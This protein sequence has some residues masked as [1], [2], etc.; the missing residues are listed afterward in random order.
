M[1][2]QT[3]DESAGPVTSSV[4]SGLTPHAA[5]IEYVA[6]APSMRN[7]PCATFKMRISP[8]CRFSPSATSA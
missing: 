4:R 1:Q 6:Y 5:C 3:D 7:S 2:H 8:Y